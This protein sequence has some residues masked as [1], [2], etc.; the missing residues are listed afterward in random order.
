MRPPRISHT[1]GRYDQTA[2][3]YWFVRH[4]ASPAHAMLTADPIDAKRF[5]SVEAAEAWATSAPGEMKKRMAEWPPIII[6]VSASVA[7]D[8]VTLNLDAEVAM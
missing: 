3:L 2:N 8:P 6:P 5:P 4:D 1:I 7:G